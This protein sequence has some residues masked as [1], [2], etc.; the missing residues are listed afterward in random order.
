[1]KP[2][3]KVLPATALLAGLAFSG[4]ADAQ[5]TF[6]KMAISCSSV[7]GP[8]CGY[9]AGGNLLGIF[10]TQNILNRQI[11]GKLYTVGY[12]AYGLEVDLYRYYASR[13]CT[14]QALGSTGYEDNGPLPFNPVEA[15]WDGTNFW[16][17][18]GLLST[19]TVQASICEGVACGSPDR[20][21]GVCIPNDPYT[22][23]FAPIAVIETP[24]LTPPTAAC[25]AAQNCVVIK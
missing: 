11:G 21:A 9:D 24:K 1:M 22:S 12:T 17:P 16:G 4:A 18:I 14:G 5:I 23:A 20:P 7:I 13:D 15:M 25:I 3:F 19:M 8:F 10:Q 6:N 2:S